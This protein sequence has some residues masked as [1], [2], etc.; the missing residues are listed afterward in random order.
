MQLGIFCILYLIYQATRFSVRPIIHSKCEGVII[1]KTFK[2][3]IPL[4]GISDFFLS[5]NGRK[6]NNDSKEKDEQ[7]NI[8]MKHAGLKVY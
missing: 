2:P 4:F 7:L 8:N 3:W 6:L 1:D 5:D